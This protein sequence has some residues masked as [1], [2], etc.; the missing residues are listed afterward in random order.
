MTNKELIEALKQVVA[1]ELVDH[2]PALL[3]QGPKV[4]KLIYESQKYDDKEVAAMLSGMSNEDKDKYVLAT[5]ALQKS[6]RE[7]NMDQMEFWSGLVESVAEAAWVV[8]AMWAQ[9]QIGR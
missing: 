6:L 5:M 1:G 4:A 2:L 9:S 7:H 3:S 8:F